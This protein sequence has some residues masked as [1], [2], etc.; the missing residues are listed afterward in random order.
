MNDLWWMRPRG[1]QAGA[2]A[3]AGLVWAVILLWADVNV[4]G[5]WGKR[6]VSVER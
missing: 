3:G 2:V 6:E 5:G 1:H 4:E